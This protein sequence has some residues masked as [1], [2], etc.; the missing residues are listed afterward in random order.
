MFIY[1]FFFFFNSSVDLINKKK[2]C[3]DYFLLLPFIVF[4]LYI[5]RIHFII[6]AFIFTWLLIPFKFHRLFFIKF[7]PFITSC[8]YIFYSSFVSIKFWENKK[9]SE[10]NPKDKMFHSIYIPNNVTIFMFIFYLLSVVIYGSS[11]NL[12]AT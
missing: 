11:R 6:E 9:S 1:I 2:T 3:F 4:F 8:V 10:K 12:L 5:R 7:S